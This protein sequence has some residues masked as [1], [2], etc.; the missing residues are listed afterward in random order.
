MEDSHGLSHFITPAAILYLPVM[1]TYL[2]SLYV[3]CR[4]VP[5]QPQAPQT[6][7]LPQAGPYI[8]TALLTSQ[9]TILLLLTLPDLPWRKELVHRIPPGWTVIFPHIPY[10]LLSLPLF[11]LLFTLPVPPVLGSVPASR[12][13]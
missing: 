10:C 6:V 11:S 9:L 13:D 2:P 12:F 1:Y 3:L 4:G 8:A 5:L 7:I